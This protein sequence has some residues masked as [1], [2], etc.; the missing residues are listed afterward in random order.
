M[1]QPSRVLV[2]YDHRKG[3]VHAVLDEVCAFLEE[4]GVR[5]TRR[6]EESE[7]G[8]LD[9]EADL[10]LV[11]GG[12]GSI[13]RAARA[14]DARQ[15]P[16]VG[17]NLG[18]L[19]FLASLSPGDFRDGLG[20]ILDGRYEVE[21]RTTLEFEIVG[22]GGKRGIALNDVTLSRAARGTLISVELHLGGRRVAQYRADGLIVSTPT[23]STAYSLAAGGPVL[24]PG[25]AAFSLTPICP[26]QLTQRPLVVPGTRPIELVLQE[27]E[28]TMVAVDGQEWTPLAAGQR[29]VVRA[30]SVRFPWIVLPER[31][32]Y[33][34][35]TSCLY[36]GGVGTPEGA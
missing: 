19:G 10:L 35:L 31:D 34:R 12:D 8:L 6:S 2:F 3:D 20:A 28:N 14:R 11:L 7:D 15:I 36:W 16:T 27:G 21:E 26:H 1:K 9:V 18:R 30:S 24:D 5:T 25:L 29:M 33:A 17:I 13:L 22:D 23:G 4:R 32:F